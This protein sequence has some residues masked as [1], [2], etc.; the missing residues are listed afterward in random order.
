MWRVAMEIARRTGGDPGQPGLFGALDLSPA[1]QPARLVVMETAGWAE[2]DEKTWE[3]FDRMRAVAGVD[4]GQSRD[5]TAICVMYRID[6]PTR[7]EANDQ[8]F[9][10][11]IGQS[12]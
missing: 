4:I 5:P 10:R 8:D 1:L 12:F 7:D 11:T 2:L 3:G 9:V 6:Q